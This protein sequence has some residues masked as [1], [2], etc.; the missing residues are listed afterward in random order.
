VRH[1]AKHTCGLTRCHM[2]APVTQKALH[3]RGLVGVSR[4]LELGRRSRRSLGDSPSCVS[5]L[6]HRRS[7]GIMAEP[8]A[9]RKR[10]SKVREISCGGEK[11]TWPRSQGLTPA[12]GAFRRSCL[13]RRAVT[14]CVEYACLW[15]R[16][17]SG[18]VM[19]PEHD[20]QQV[21]L[22][23]EV[24]RLRVHL[25]HYI[26]ND[27]SLISHSQLAM[28]DS[29]GEAAAA[30]QPASD[31]GAGSEREGDGGDPFEWLTLSLE[32][33]DGQWDGLSDFNTRLDS[34]LQSVGTPSEHSTP[35][36]APVV[37]VGVGVLVVDPHKPGQVLV[38][39]RKGSHGAGTLALPGMV[40]T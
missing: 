34:E 16:R 28:G 12:V 27:D 32:G 38:G 5:M 11:G 40:T 15:V 9:K 4:P 36:P 17:T 33:D 35:A 2:P 24:K 31:G 1:A 8:P 21:T 26:D 13:R 20:T 7:R 25:K 18:G 6:A 29:Q 10:P 14:W 37:R 3:E 22:A 30:S 19:V 23:R 39:T